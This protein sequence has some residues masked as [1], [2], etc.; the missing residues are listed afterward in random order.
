ML[1]HDSATELWEIHPATRKRAGG[2]SAVAGLS[3]PIHVSV[4]YAT[5]HRRPGIAVH[6]RSI[7]GPNERTVVQG[8]PVTTAAA[9]LIDV[10]ASWPGGQLE[11]AVNEADRRD[12]IDPETLRRALDAV[13]P[14]AGTARLRRLLDRQTFRL[15]D[16]EL[17]RQFLALVSGAGL[18]LPQTGTRLN[19]FTVDFFWPDLGLVVETDGLRYHR[20]AAQQTRDRLRDQA[21]AA[22]GL[23]ALRFTNGQIRFEP[24][25]VIEVLREVA[26]RLEAAGATGRPNRPRSA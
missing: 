15:T 22:A 24:A 19:G 23:T 21:H 25:H 12:L 26:G 8:I 10:A 5:R 1:S 18:P 6:R 16:S 3:R 20:T 7:L 14:R 13:K 17:E 2:R 4:P 11:A 9:T